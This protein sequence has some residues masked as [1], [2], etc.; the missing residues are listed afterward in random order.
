M[1]PRYSH[2]EQCREINE[3]SIAGDE[4]D[5]RTKKA[6]ERLEHYLA[7][8]VE[9]GDHGIERA[10]DP[11]EDDVSMSPNK[12]EDKVAPNPEEDKTEVVKGPERFEI[13]SPSK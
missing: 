9:E 12:D 11:R 8:R 10:E 2:S 13:G 7:Q 3:T 1:G 6:K 5:D 4:N